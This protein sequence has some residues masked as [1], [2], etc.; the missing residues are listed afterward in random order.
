MDPVGSTD[1]QNSWSSLQ[2]FRIKRC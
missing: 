1:L 2:N